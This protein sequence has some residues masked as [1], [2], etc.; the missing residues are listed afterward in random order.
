[1]ITVFAVL[2][3]FFYKNPIDIDTNSIAETI[4]LQLR[5][6]CETYYVNITT[7]P[8]SNVSKWLYV[9]YIIFV[10]LLV[11]NTIICN[12]EAIKKILKVKFKQ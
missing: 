4:L 6:L 8:P 2:V 5:K 7:K 10:G 11:I 9:G 3:A 12:I 1:M